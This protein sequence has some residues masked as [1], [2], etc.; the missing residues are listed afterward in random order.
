MSVAAGAGSC[1]Y[2]PLRIR[3]QL[4]TA[5]RFAG[6]LTEAGDIL[7]ISILPVHEVSAQN[8]FSPEKTA[9]G[10]NSSIRTSKNNDQFSI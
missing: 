3:S 10:V 6:A 8:A 7:G 5:G 4:E 9:N 2:D 1:V